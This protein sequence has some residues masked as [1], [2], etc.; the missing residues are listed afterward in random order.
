LGMEADDA[1]G[2][3]GRRRPSAVSAQTLYKVLERQNHSMVIL[4]SLIT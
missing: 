1:E 4:R 3:S 2:T